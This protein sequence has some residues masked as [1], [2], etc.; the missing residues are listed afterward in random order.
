MISISCSAGRNHE[1]HTDQVV[2]ERRSNARGFSRSLAWGR[3]VMKD[4]DYFEVGGQ[5]VFPIYG[6]S[7]GIAA[8]FIF[9]L[10]RDFNCGRIRPVRKLH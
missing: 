8:S 4:I 1:R 5:T 6:A 10:I 9:Y 2:G 3:A 7:G